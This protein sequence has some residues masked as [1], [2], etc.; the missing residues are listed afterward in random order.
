MISKYAKRD[1]TLGTKK[2]A[3]LLIKKV[4]IESTHSSLINLINSNTANNN[5][6]IIEPGIKRLGKIRAI[7]KEVHSPKR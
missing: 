2:K 7:E 5:M 3:M 4:L 1:T 6:P